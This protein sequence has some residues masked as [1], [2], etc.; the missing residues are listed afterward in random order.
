MYV[1]VLLPHDSIV[2]DVLTDWPKEHRLKLP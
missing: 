1:N 2:N